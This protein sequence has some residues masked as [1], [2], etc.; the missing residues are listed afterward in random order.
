MNVIPK[1]IAWERIPTLEQTEKMKWL[2]EN[3]GPSSKD[4]W[5]LE[6]DYDLENLIFSDEIATMYYLRWM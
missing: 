5:Y 1:G 2:T 6:L 4:T 3:F